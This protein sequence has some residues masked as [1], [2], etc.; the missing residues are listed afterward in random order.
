[1]RKNI[2]HFRSELSFLTSYFILPSYLICKNLK[3]E[4]PE[5][6]IKHLDEINQIMINSRGSGGSG[7]GGGVVMGLF[8]PTRVD[9][10]KDEDFMDWIQGFNM[11]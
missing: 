3:F 6:I 7:G 2:L 11:K 10:G 4:Q 9:I 5:A 1:M 8:D